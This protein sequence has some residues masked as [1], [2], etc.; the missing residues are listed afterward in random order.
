MIAPHPNYR[1]EEVCG[2]T[3][4]TRSV[5]FRW[6]NSHG[7]PSVDKL[8]V[9]VRALLD[10]LDEHVMGLPPPPNQPEPIAVV[11]HED[12]KYVLE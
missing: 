3:R 1:P 5:P 11:N 8:A 4:Y 6:T 7:L 10:Q 9:T 12:D 2:M